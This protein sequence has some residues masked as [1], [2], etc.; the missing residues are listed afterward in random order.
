[1]ESHL[2]SC[3]KKRGP[4]SSLEQET[5]LNLWRAMDLLSQ[6]HESFFRKHGLSAQQY[7]VL[8]I[9]RGEHPKGSVMSEIRRRL[10]TRCPDVT[11]MVDHL[12]KQGL[13]T[14]VTPEGNRRS[15]VAKITK[16][17]LRLLGSMDEGLLDCHRE[18]LDC[19]NTAE[20]RFLIDVTERI[21]KRHGGLRSTVE[22]RL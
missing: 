18:Q 13:A 2:A 4:F 15:V 9:L 19:L 6:I 5:L 3:I 14:R 11:R 20:L 17:G 16:K 7:N 10:I 1:M 21:Q 22:T 8:R 12:V